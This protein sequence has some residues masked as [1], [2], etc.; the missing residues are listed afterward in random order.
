MLPDGWKAAK[1]ADVCQ[2]LNGRA[3]AK[4][5]LKSS[6]KYPVL[7]VGNFFTN[8]SWY[9]SDLELDGNKYCD[10]GDLLYA[11]SASFSPRIWG[12]GKAIY[13]YHIWKILVDPEFIEQEYLYYF[14]E[15]DVDNIKSSEGTGSTMIHV[16]KG[17]MEQRAF[18]LPPL[19]E[20]RRIVEVLRSADDAIS[21][22][23]A[24]VQQTDSLW[25]AMTETLI[26]HLEG[27]RP[28]CV[29]PLG[30]ALRASDYGVNAALTVEANGHPVLRMGN[31]QDGRIDLSDLKWGEVTAAEAN[32][33]AL[34]EGDIL[35]N[36]TN[37][38]DLVGKVALVR[39]PTDCL[40]A[41]YIVRLSVDR[42]VADPY[43]LFAVAHSTRAQ[44]AFKSIATPGAS[45]S[46]INPTNL[47]KHPVPLPE[48]AT[49]QAIA[50]QLR[51]VE[52]ARFAVQQ[53][54]AA[55]QII[56]KDLAVNLLSGRV[57]TPA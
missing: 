35:F 7:R 20:Q 3:Y 23:Q 2:F 44:D 50:A 51:S 1:L 40:Y 22:T 16:T 26:W 49:Q 41:S 47:K 46:N 45:Q 18:F 10:S 4:E 38:R 54:L 32:A 31:I 34:S 25:Q 8:D 48:L 28:D 37:S 52:D 29:R 42:A 15:W 21:A 12:G 27:E 53:E 33:L 30:T 13:H 19:D 14:L 39:E 55:L 24:L 36:R 43:Y 17:A 57:R 5:E 11:W 56:K 9:Y 6:G